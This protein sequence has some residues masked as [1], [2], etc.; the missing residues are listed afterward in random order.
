MHHL[1]KITN[2][3]NGKIYIGQSNNYKHRWSRHVYFA[4]NP[5]KTG[6]YIHRAMAKYGIENF[7]YEIIATCLTQEDANE[8]ESVLIVQYNSR[9]NEYGYN[10]TVGG[11]YGGHSEETKQKLRKAT[12]NQIATKGPPGLGSKRTTEQ[13]EKM[14][15]AQQ[16]RTWEYTAEVRKNMSDAHKGKKQPPEAVKKRADMMRARK[17]DMKCSASGCDIMDR[18]HSSVIDGIRYCAMHSYRVKTT[19]S[20]APIPRKAH[21]RKHFTNEQIISILSDK[22]TAKTIGKDFNVSETVI[23][24]IRKEA[25]QSKNI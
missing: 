17:G 9:N 12:L 21:N 7:K 5:E 20:A 10:L 4:K 1:Y 3:L 19:G 22:R 14:S 11:D 18:R 25:K 2:Q 16:N 8:I 23:L 13:K 6:Q 24:R 15:F